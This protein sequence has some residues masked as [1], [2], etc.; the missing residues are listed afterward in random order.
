M[1]GMD[2][3]ELDVSTSGNRYALVFQD[4]LSKWP[5]VYALSNRRAEIVAKCLQDLAWRHGVPNKIIH[6]RAAEFLADVL[7]ET[8]ELLGVRQ[9]P[10]SGGHPQTDGLVERFNR[11]LKQMLTKLVKKGG[12]NWDE[13][14]GPVLL[15]YR[16]TPHASSGMSPFYLLYGR[17]PQLPSQLNFQ[18]PVVRYPVKETEYGKELEVQLKQ[19]R[20]VAQQNICKKQKEQKRYY[21]QKSKE[22]ELQVGD[23]V[24]LKTEPRFKLD[25]SFKGPFVVKSLTTTN[26]MIK[27]KDDD[28]AE[29]LNVS[30]Q[31]LSRCEPAMSAA[32][33]WVGHCNKLRKR[34]RIRNQH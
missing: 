1:I 28:T 23:L 32:I 4:Y 3:V 17:N 6:D 30:R 13:L 12:H 14:L 16:T 5:E 29:L 9:L 11:T 22:V 20:R 31:R 24:M 18:A 2:F 10:T 15:A 7:Q 21:D 25:R 33:P 27:L 19:A 26:G 34:R 8:A